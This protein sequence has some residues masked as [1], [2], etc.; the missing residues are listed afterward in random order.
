MCGVVSY[1]VCGIV[2]FV[3]RGGG[4]WVERWSVECSILDRSV[5]V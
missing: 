3:R 5:V 1:V 4:A 2:G